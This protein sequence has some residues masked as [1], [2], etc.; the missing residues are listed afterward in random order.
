MP[1]VR[2]M[3]NFHKR[4]SLGCAI[5]ALAQIAFGYLFGEYR[6]LA[7]PISITCA[8]IT[9]VLWFCLPAISRRFPMKGISTRYYSI[10][11]YLL[12]PAFFIAFVCPY[13][14]YFFFKNKFQL[15]VLTLLGISALFS[16]ILAY[17]LYG[18]S[19]YKFLSGSSRSSP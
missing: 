5:W 10:L 4:V 19:L 7:Y 11:R 1:A 2:T 12:F 6:P 15:G 8:A 16:L 17:R 3:N 18:E 9:A 13:L 14:H